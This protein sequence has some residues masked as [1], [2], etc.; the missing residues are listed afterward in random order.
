M[1]DHLATRPCARRTRQTALNRQLVWSRFR[2]LGAPFFSIEPQHPMNLSAARLP[3]TSLSLAVALGW[4]GLGAAQSS[5]AAA[6]ELSGS[7]R[8][9]YESISAQFR[10]TTPGSACRRRSCRVAARSRPRSSGGPGSPRDR[11]VRR[12]SYDRPRRRSR[13]SDPSSAGAGSA[14]HT[15][16]SCSGRRAAPTDSSRPSAMR[17]GSCDRARRRSR[18]ARRGRRAGCPFYSYFGVTTRF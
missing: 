6:F 2:C 16:R 13:S 12:G 11:S 7:Q 14:A 3:A 15:P 18:A 1:L 5:D 9:R 17:G 4:A 8:A 10:R